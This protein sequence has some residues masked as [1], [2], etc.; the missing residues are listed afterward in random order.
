MKY[1]RRAWSWLGL[2]GPYE[3]V[4][5][6]VGEL[7]VRFVRINRGKTWSIVEKHSFPRGIEV[8]VKFLIEGEE[9]WE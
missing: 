5:W 6:R 7:L 3:M 9:R 1:K 8:T 4:S 2:G